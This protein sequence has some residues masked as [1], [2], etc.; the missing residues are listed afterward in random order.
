M[1]RLYH[2]P[3]GGERRELLFDL[4]EVL[5]VQKSLLVGNLIEA[6]I[7]E[8]ID[9]ISFGVLDHESFRDIENIYG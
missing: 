8:I 7:C 1:L 2:F 9:H 6:L 3:A 4:N 5:T